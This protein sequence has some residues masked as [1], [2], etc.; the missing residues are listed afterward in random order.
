[1]ADSIR[2][3]ASHRNGLTTVRSI[4]RHP[5]NT[6]FEVDSNSGTLIP[7]YFIKEVLCKHNDTVVMRCDWSRAVSR[8]PYL[9][10]SFEGA[11]PGDTVSI[12]WIDTKGLSESATIKIQ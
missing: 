9:S 2:L 1:M 12:S 11:K 4:I 6:G 8:N 10:F 7:V 3:R 5:M